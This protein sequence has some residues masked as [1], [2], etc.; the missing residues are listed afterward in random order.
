[1]QVAAM[2]P[3]PHS[4]F[5]NQ[6][7]RRPGP[8]FSDKVR[9]T[10]IFMHH[11]MLMSCSTGLPNEQTRDFRGE[12][13][14]NMRT[15]LRLFEVILSASLVFSHS[16]SPSFAQALEPSAETLTVEPVV[17]EATEPAAQPQE[18]AEAEAAPLVEAEPSVSSAAATSPV[19]PSQ[20]EPATATNQTPAP[21]TPAFGA[22]G[23]L[24]YSYALDLPSFRGLE[25]E[26]ELDYDSSRKTKLGGLYQGWL[27]YGWGLD[28]L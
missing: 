1:M 7:H 13:M 16:F 11:A 22:D 26:I 3:S 25:P 8:A 28:R 5:A 14:K 19:Y 4:G 21:A 18:P 6:A 15:G 27:G 24:R 12:M 23:A 2:A 9:P 17:E 20:A 10:A